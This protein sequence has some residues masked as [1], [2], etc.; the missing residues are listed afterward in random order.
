[1]I[2]IIILALFG[3]FS[4]VTISSV[5]SNIGKFSA[6]EI[7]QDRPIIFRLLKNLFP[8]NK[9]QSFYFFLGTTKFLLYPI[10]IA[11]LFYTLAPYFSKPITILILFSITFILEFLA[12]LIATLFPTTSLRVFSFITSLYLMIFFPLLSPIFLVLKRFTPHFHPIKKEPL[13]KEDILEMIK[14]MGFDRFLDAHD[15]RIFISLASFKEKVAREIMVPRIHIFS[16]PSSMS[17]KEA[18]ESLLEEG[19]SRIPIYKDNLDNIIGVLMYKDLLHAYAH[20]GGKQPLLDLSI[21]TLVKPVIYT[22]E[23]KK[24]SHLFQLFRKKQSHMAI[25]VNEYGGTEGIVTIEDILEELVGEIADE[26]DIEEEKK[27]WKLSNNS[28]VVDAKMS[29]IDLEAKL[30]IKIPPSTEYETIGGFVFHKAGAI[31]QK[32]WKLQLDDYDLE[33]LISNERCIE[34]IKITLHSPP[35]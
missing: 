29:I 19:Y 34:K 30:E 35:Q 31:P 20:A 21:E 15:K 24:I 4:I 14:D 28:W 22:P 18:T 9:W 12:R 11:I 33:V 13:Q 17:I 3:V 6:Q 2:Y 10:F 27:F 26:Y 32:G 16:L 5:I 25:I 8:N 1:M 7:I 23:N